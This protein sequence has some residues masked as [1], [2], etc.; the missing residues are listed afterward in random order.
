MG[1]QKCFR[2]FFEV[3]ARSGRVQLAPQLAPLAGLSQT[4]KKSTFSV[5]N[6]K[7][8]LGPGRSN[9][10]LGDTLGV[11]KCFRTL[12]EARVRSGWVQMGP[13]MALFAC[14]SLLRACAA[15]WSKVD[16]FGQKSKIFLSPRRSNMGLGDH[17]GCPKVFPRI[18]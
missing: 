6:R 9:M 11:Q 7:N 2:T 3:G 14:I 8:F 18:F 16:F 5:K 13:Q 17:I 12:F 10:G 15:R 1:V 4:V